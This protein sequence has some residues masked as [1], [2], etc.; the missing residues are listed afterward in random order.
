MKKRFKFWSGFFLVFILILTVTGCG[1]E[2]NESMTCTRTTNQNNIKTS[3][4]YNINYTN[5]YVTRVKSVETVESSN[6]DILNTYKEQIESLYSAYKN[7][8]YYEYNVKIE[9]SKLTSTVDINYEKINTDK[10]LEIDS[11]NGQ[12]IKDGKIKVSDIKS[13]YESMGAICKKTS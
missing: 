7:V 1:S 10:L 9:D 5:D 11:A 3:L 2:K 4:K 12:L 6:I 13:V 8:K